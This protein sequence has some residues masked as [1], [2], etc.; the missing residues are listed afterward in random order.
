MPTPTSARPARTIASLALGAML[1]T[2]LAPTVA[3]DGGLEVT[4]PFPAVA[5]APGSSA[6]FDLAVTLTQVTTT[7]GLRVEGAPAEWNASLHGGGFVVDGVTAGP[8]TTGE[9]RLDV[10]VPA[11]AAAGTTTI[12]VIAEAD[13]RTDTLPITVRVNADVAGDVTLTTDTP[14]LTGASDASFT[15]NVTLNNDT[16][17]DL[18]VSARATTPAPGWDL[19]TTISGQ[20]QAAATVVEAGG[21]VTLNVA[22]T[23]PANAAA[24]AYPITLE[25][26]AGDQTVTAELAVEITG[27][28]TLDLATPNDLLS[29]SGGAGSPT[30]IA[31]E[32][33][34]TGTAPLNEVA[35]TASP[36]TNWTVTFDKEGGVIEPIA[37]GAVGTITATVTP[38]GEAVSGDYVVSFTAQNADADDEVEIRFTVET[39]PIWAIVG[40]L[41]IVAILGGLFYVFR[42]YGRR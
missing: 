35:L 4:T 13:G 6:S 34:N 21:T 41:V 17:R 42:T 16:A 32:V 14:T 7:V 5:V 15:F 9:V 11:T 25:A 40:L 3:A 2:T 1:L 37:P 27:S 19:A 26:T 28:F 39:S 38:S 30:T 33:T 18:T 24:G 12:N 23:A 10:D 8:G 20:D 31:L 29:A 36:P 22:A